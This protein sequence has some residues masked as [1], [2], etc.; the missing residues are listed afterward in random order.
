MTD[1][2]VHPERARILESSVEYYAALE[3]VLGQRYE[4]AGLDHLG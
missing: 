1:S 4:N 2:S 3:S